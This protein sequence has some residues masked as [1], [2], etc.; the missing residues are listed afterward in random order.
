MTLL[1]FAAE[2]RGA[3]LLPV[4]AW[5]LPRSTPLL[6]ID[7]SRLHG[8]QQQ[9]RRTPRLRP[10]D[11][12]DRRTDGRTIV[13]LTLLRILCDQCQQRKSTGVTSGCQQ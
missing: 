13:S 1:A 10:L 3:A 4:G 6:S 8:A 11:G 5:R 9:T 7:M 12:T 2:R